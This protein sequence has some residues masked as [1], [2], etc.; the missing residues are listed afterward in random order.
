[1]VVTNASRR[2]WKKVITALFGVSSWCLHGETE[3]NY[4]T[5]SDRSPD[6][7]SSGTSPEYKSEVLPFE[8]PH[9]LR[10]S[11]VLRILLW[12]LESGVWCLILSCMGCWSC[13]LCFDTFV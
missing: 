7:G 10:R 6:Q 8:I 2:M 5:S 1:M 11:A 4:T 9:S 13:L 12:L 3:E